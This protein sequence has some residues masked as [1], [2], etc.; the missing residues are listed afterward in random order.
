MLFES[1]GDCSMDTF[2]TCLPFTSC[3]PF[4]VKQF[5][6]YWCRQSTIHS[7]VLYVQ[8]S[9]T[10]M[11]E[12]IQY[13]IQDPDAMLFHYYILITKQKQTIN[14]NKSIEFSMMFNVVQW[15]A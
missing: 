10:D 12:W 14:K 4:I 8:M 5:M 9:M 1:I 2:F 15:K 11:L 7:Y 3:V 13:S 6:G